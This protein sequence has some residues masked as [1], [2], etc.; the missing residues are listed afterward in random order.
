M[1]AP[2]DSTP[3]AAAADNA[4]AEEFCRSLSLEHG[5]VRDFLA[6][7]R[8]RLRQTEVELIRQIER[9]AGQLQ[10]F[11]QRGLELANQRADQPIEAAGHPPGAAGQ[12]DPEGLFRRYEMALC[13]LREL[14]ARH[15][16]LQ[17]HLAEVEKD[18]A[19]VPASASGGVLDWETEK[20][21][22]LAALE[23]SE[24]LHEPG[25]GA[26][27]LQIQE[28]VAQT[29]RLLA[30]KD[31]QIEEL[32]KAAENSTSGVA[33]SAAREEILDQDVV[34]REERENLRRLQDEWR[35]K[36]RQAEVDLSVQRAK[37]ARQEAEINE[38]LRRLQPSG[39]PDAQSPGTPRTPEKPPRGRW[40]SLLGLAG[41]DPPPGKR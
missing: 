9:L 10:A 35:D 7:R 29:Q 3:A 5:R 2:L 25:A 16:D 41:D 6:A 17:K 19:Q 11:G 38:K 8:Q 21:R 4:W 32:R 33:A 28:I 14:K 23:A 12:P 30:E 37:L 40:L 31:R 24:E 36:L 22:I 1:D 18:R 13:D 20:R 26:E 34:V 39:E 27:R 15:A